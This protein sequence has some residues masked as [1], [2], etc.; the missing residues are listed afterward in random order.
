MDNTQSVPMLSAVRAGEQFCG[1]AMVRG[2]ERK[3]TRGGDDYVQFTLQDRGGT[4]KVN[5]WQSSELLPPGT[6][7]K[8]AGTGEA[9]GGEMQLKIDGTKFRVAKPEDEKSASDFLPVAPEAPE[10]MMAEVRDTV[11][12]FEDDGLRAL[13]AALLDRAGDDM[14]AFPGAKSMHHAEIGGLLHHVTSMLRAAKALV[15]VYTFL[16]KDLLFAG[17]IVH[18]LGKMAEMRRD[19]LGLVSEYT[20]PGRLLGHISLGVAAI[21]ETGRALGVD[22]ETVLMLQH[23]VLSHHG[24]PDYGSPVRAAF[25]EAEVLSQLDLLD[26][27][28]FEMQAALAN[29]A[30]GQFSGRVW[31]LENR[32]IY[33]ATKG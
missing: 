29:V 8:L 20:A 17:V 5:R 3:K 26:A 19:E 11:A 22:G 1:F 9:F 6:I 24:S 25:P 33:K 28:L 12:A 27:R 2:A 16:R 31:A 23:M 15:Q 30:P 14:L 4:M 7:V 13:V 10:A 21:G 18:D 32:E